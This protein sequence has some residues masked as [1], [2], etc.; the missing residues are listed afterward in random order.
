MAAFID[1]CAHQFSRSF[2]GD[3]LS[4]VRTSSQCWCSH[5]ECDRDPLT[6]VVAQRIAN[7]TRT[8]SERYMEPFQVLKY[9]PGQFYRTHHDQNSGLFTPQAR[10][11]VITPQPSGL[12]TPRTRWLFTT[13]AE[14]RALML[15][16]LLVTRL[17]TVTYYRDLLP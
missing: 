12:C 16:A 3:V 17:T 7:V 4:P 9:Q 14:R 10:S 11:P 8:A 6:H 13:H 5:N 1:G 2:A 15:P